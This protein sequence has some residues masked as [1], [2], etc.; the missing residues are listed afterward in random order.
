MDT[1]DDINYSTVNGNGDRIEYSVKDYN[2]P[3]YH[4]EKTVATNTVT[5]KKDVTKRIIK[6]SQEDLISDVIIVSV[7]ATAINMIGNG[8][9][10]LIYSIKK[11]NKKK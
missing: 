7:S 9:S 10:H 3:F 1:K 11:K 2:L 5:G 4:F 8:L 6:K